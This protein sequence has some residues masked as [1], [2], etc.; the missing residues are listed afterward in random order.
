M[1]SMEY[2]CINQC[3]FYSNNIRNLYQSMSTEDQQIFPFDMRDV[4]WTQCFCNGLFGMRLFLAKEDPKT[5]PRA[6]E[7]M[8]R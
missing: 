6:I 1:A 7:S 4:D 2:F 8:N 3:K 5:I